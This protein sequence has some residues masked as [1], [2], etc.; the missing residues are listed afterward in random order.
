ML[1][2]HVLELDRQSNT[3]GIL[4]RLLASVS[5]VQYGRKDGD[6]NPGAFELPGMEY[7]VLFPVTGA[8]AIG[9]GAWPG[10]N[11]A[12]RALVVVDATWRQARRMFRRIEALRG[13]PVVRLAPTVL[14]RWLLRNPHQPGAVSTLEAVAAAFAAT[15]DESLASSLLEAYGRLAQRILVMRGKAAAVRPRRG[16][17][18]A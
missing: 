4:E 14:P 1:I 10:R 12:R 5:V 18:G 2:Q 7:A 9:P 15:G 11:G 8:P 6:L 3:G 17:R 16:P 13:L